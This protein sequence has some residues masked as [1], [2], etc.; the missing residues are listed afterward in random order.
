MRRRSEGPSR[1]W[2][3]L[4]MGAASHAGLAADVTVAPPPGAGFAV[5]DA[6]NSSDRLRV[7]EAGVLIPGIG[8]ATARDSL[9]CFNGVT[10]QLGPCSAGLTGATGRPGPPAPWAPRARP[11]PR[12]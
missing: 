9:T 6:A 12:G 8:A 7:N 2:L 1:L 3:A 4:W 10:G 5:R 11:D